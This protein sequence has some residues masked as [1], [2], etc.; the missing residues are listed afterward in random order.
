VFILQYRSFV[1]HNTFD[2]RKAAAV[3]LIGLIR[4]ST[5]KQKTGRQYDALDPSA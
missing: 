4:V 1:P 3:A 5:D 2:E